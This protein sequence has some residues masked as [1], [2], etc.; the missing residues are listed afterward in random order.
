MMPFV[1]QGFF[2]DQ[3]LP[4]AYGKSAQFTTKPAKLYYLTAFNKGS[5]CWIELY[6]AASATGTPRVIPCP[7]NGVVGWAQIHMRTGIFVR[8][9]DAASGGALIG[10]DDVKFDCGFTDQVV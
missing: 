5:A 6:D 3:G 10:A 8:A 4:Q 1:V 2:A 9:V 7:A